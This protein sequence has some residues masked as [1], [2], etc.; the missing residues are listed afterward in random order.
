MTAATQSLFSRTADEIDALARD[1]RKPEALRKAA[2]RVQAALTQRRLQ[3]ALAELERA[4]PLIDD[5]TQGLSALTAAAREAAAAAPSAGALSDA[6]AALTRAPA[7]TAPEKSLAVVRSTG[8]ADVGAELAARFATMTLDPARAGDIAYVVRCAERGR[9]RYDAVSARIGTPWRMIAA[10]HALEASFRFDR[11]LHNGD[12]LSARTV[13]VPKGRPAVGA[14][15]FT[16]EESA[17]DALAGHGLADIADWSQARQLYELERYNGF[18]YRRRGCVS[19]Y[20]WAGSDVY[21]AGK[22]VADG[23]YDPNA[24][25]KQV[26]AAVILRALGQE[27]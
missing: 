25:S 26:G 8:F 7:T 3:A 13:H 22:Y 20:L 15:P 23:K 27:A 2:R 5:L 17:V 12:P 6:L 16:W 4:T 24:V 10:I 9:A 11:H 14:P 18:G 1:P 19:P 21:V